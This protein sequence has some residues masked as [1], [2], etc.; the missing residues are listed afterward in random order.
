ML[1]YLTGWLIVQS[2]ILSATYLIARSSGGIAPHE[3]PM[4]AAS[5]T[6]APVIHAWIG[7]ELIH[8]FRPRR[9][10]DTR[11]RRAVA[12][13]LT[14]AM[15]SCIGLVPTSAALAFMP[16]GVPDIAATSLCALVVSAAATLMLA[17]QRPG[18]CIHCAYDLRGTSTTAVCPECGKLPCVAA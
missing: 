12:R 5:L 14:G 15:A 6:L 2:L 3:F 16:A 4:L 17:R 1:L 13:L 10:F 9:L 8:R 18:A 11:T 7:A